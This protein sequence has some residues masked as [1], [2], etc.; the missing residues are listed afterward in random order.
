MSRYIWVLINRN[1]Y[2]KVNNMA[3]RRNIS[4]RTLRKASPTNVT[5]ADL[6]GNVAL[7]RTYNDGI[8]IA[9]VLGDVGDAIQPGITAKIENDLGLRDYTDEEI[10][11]L[12]ALG[13]LPFAG[14]IAK[15]GMKGVN[16]LN[17]AS[18]LPAKG[19]FIRSPL[20]KNLTP[21]EQAATDDYITYLNTRPDRYEKIAGVQTTPEHNEFLNPTVEEFIDDAAG[22]L[23]VTRKPKNNDVR[24]EGIS[25]EHAGD[26]AYYRHNY[27][28]YDAV[29][30]DAY[31]NFIKANKAGK[32]PRFNGRDYY[33]DGKFEPMYYTKPYGISGIN[34]NLKGRLYEELDDLMP[35]TIDAVE[36]R[37]P[38]QKDYQKI[39]EA[40]N[41]AHPRY[42]MLDSYE[43]PVYKMESELK[44]IE[45][46]LP[47]ITDPIEKTRLQQRSQKLRNDLN[48]WNIE[49]ILGDLD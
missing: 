49:L 25:P 32:M 16:A 42:Y 22:N 41:R 47:N 7:P 35:G 2:S 18:R 9:N 27:T 40:Y 46:Q 26:A 34:K 45:E 13:M 37:G 28:N 48:D 21:A 12:F 15:A 10:Q 3:K 6:A 29:E 14:K 19:G 44:R 31:D 24:L 36:G 5:P 20:F 39:V 4:G 11:L 38:R 30:D 33:D 8:S 1:K 17:K 43:S 23:R